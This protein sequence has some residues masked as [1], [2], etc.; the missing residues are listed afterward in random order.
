MI[1]PTG[2]SFMMVALLLSVVGGF[3]SESRRCFTTWVSTRKGGVDKHDEGAFFESLRA[4]QESE[5]PPPIESKPQSILDGTSSGDGV[6]VVDK[7][8]Q[9]IA[10]S[11]RQSLN[12]ITILVAAAFVATYYLSG[13]E[14][15][16]LLAPEESPLRF[17]HPAVIDADALL[18][19]EL[20]EG[21]FY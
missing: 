15:G 5:L 12:V 18:R 3:R 1:K 16:M 21:N 4:R 8:V 17:S 10:I 9:Q 13:G 7:G 2:A 19:N 20:N 6:E 11:T 14:N